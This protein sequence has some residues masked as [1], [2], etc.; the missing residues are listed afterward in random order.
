MRK[1]QQEAKPTDY[2][3]FSKEKLV[4]ILSDREKEHRKIET[5]YRTQVDELEAELCDAR[6][7]IISLIDDQ[8]DIDQEL[9]EI[10][11]QRQ[12]FKSQMQ[13]LE[14]ELSKKVLE[15]DEIFHN[16]ELDQKQIHRYSQQLEEE[17]QKIE[18]LNVQTT[19]LQDS[20]QKEKQAGFE[21]NK[22][23][24]DAK[25]EILEQ[26]KTLEELQIE[27]GE[28]KRNQEFAENLTDSN[29]KDAIMNLS[30]IILSKDKSHTLTDV[31]KYLINQV[32]G[33]KCSKLIEASEQKIEKLNEKNKRLRENFSNAAILAD[34]WF[35]EFISLC[36]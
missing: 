20:L 14:I 31:Q 10:R 2:N 9:F 19:T 4:L 11:K 21:L 8:N 24:S 12:D 1:N 27:V 34:M 3:K 23:L 15:K 18:M 22:K 5:F 26:S 6:E 17:H 7:L 13:S 30:M 32:F 16:F 25:A 29:T 33:T 35:N 28:L 36:D